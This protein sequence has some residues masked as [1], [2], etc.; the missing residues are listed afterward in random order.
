MQKLPLRIPL[1]Q[2]LLRLSD[3][4]QNRGICQIA[5]IEPSVLPR[6]HLH[7]E[8]LYT[9]KAPSVLP[10]V[11][12]RNPQLQVRVFPCP[13]EDLSCLH[14]IDPPVRQDETGR[15]MAPHIF[16]SSCVALLPG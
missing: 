13:D 8:R 12:S 6:T 2:H 5:D 14:L 3:L 11:R 10:A 7:V 4:C 9:P 16:F 15:E 1:Q